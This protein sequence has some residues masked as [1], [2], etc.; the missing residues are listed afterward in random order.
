MVTCCYLVRDS[1]GY[2]FVMG[3]ISGAFL[4]LESGNW[5]SYSMENLPIGGK[6]KT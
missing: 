4:R 3:V 6:Y 2:G 5:S 1:S